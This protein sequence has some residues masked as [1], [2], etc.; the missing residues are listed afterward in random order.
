MTS[1][2]P[3]ISP[4]D[5]LRTL[6]ASYAVRARGEGTRRAYRSAWRQYE[7]WCNGLGWEVW[8]PPEGQG[9][10]EER[11][12]LYLAGLAA[13]G[14]SVATVRVH[15][16]AILSAHRLAGVSLDS[17]EPRLAMILEGIIRTRGLAPARQ[18]SPLTRE[19]LEL[20][21]QECG[22]EA[23][24]RRDRCLLLLGFGA[25]LRRSE[26]V[27]LD[28]G[29][30]TVVPERGLL[31]RV[32]RSKTDPRGEGTVLAIHRAATPALD[33]VAAL[34]HWLAIRGNP[35]DGALFVRLDRNGHPGT[36]RLS[37]R[38]VAL[39]VKRRA[40][41]AGLDPTFYAG[42]SLRAGLATSAAEREASLHDL[43]R[44]TRHRSPE[45]ARRYMRDTEVWKNNVTK[46]VFGE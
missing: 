42:H 16:A 18:V 41:A 43:M 23:A 14:R 15:L 25:A 33:G 38:G 35:E 21:V 37:D 45:V 40:E 17:R 3:A 1:D 31:V 9:G 10:Q 13:A 36:Q 46:R 30:V 11:V 28:A 7:R 8:P 22:D 12:G 32:R 6:A 34:H 39:I 26:L 19:R 44:Q 2:L 27:A 20:L 4:S 29:D 5:Q 24:G